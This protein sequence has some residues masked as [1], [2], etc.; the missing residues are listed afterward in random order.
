MCPAKS[1]FAMAKLTPKAV[2]AYLASKSER[3]QYRLMGSRGVP[4]KA[5]RRGHRLKSNRRWQAWEIELLGK[6][7]DR[8]ACRKTGRTLSALSTKRVELKIPAIR[9]HQLPWT[10]EQVA[11]LGKLPDKEAA[12]IIGCY[13]SN[14]ARK[15]LELG[16]PYTAQIVK[17]W[18]P[19]QDRLLGTMPDD[20]L[21]RQLQRSRQAVSSRRHILGIA[22]APNSKFRRWTKEEIA[23]LGKYP[24]REVAKRLGRTGLAVEQKRLKLRIFRRRAKRKLRG[25]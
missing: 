9:T 17:Y 11:L 18:T 7:P 2:R 5:G 20:V 14:V 15:R 13:Y 23:L 19:E 10:P 12:R 1:R 16:I 4:V 22:V 21:A 3:E 6:M 25:K 8:E 24:D